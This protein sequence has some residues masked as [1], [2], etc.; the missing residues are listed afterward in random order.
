MTT[1]RSPILRRSALTLA[2]A[3]LFASSGSHA[4]AQS[5]EKRADVTTPPGGQLVDDN[6]APNRD[7][8]PLQVAPAGDAATQPRQITSR[9]PRGETTP[10]LNRERRD[11]RAG[12]QLYQG[13]RTAQ[14]SEPLSN[15]AEGWPQGVVRLSGSDRCDPATPGT[16]PR[17]TCAHAIETRAAE[18]ERKSPLVLSPEQRLLVDQR[19]R[20]APSTAEM[21][22]R[23]IGRNDIDANASDAQSVASLVLGQPSAGQVTAPSAPSSALDPTTATGALVQAIIEGTQAAQSR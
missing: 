14:P 22:V 16:A 12:A 2:V 15:P 5:G 11:T 6:G 3:T 19:L 18:F 10:Q 13:R 20:E 9:T 21:A 4:A 17:A 8:P 1:S 7:V 23:R